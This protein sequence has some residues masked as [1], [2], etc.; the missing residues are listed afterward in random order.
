MKQTPL[1]AL[2]GLAAVPI[3]ASSSQAAKPL[4][5][6][7]VIGTWRNPKGSVYV[8]TELCGD[9][10]C[11]RIIC[12]DS[13][14]TAKAQS[15]GTRTLVGTS[16]FENYRQRDDGSWKGRVFI[17]DRRGWFNSTMTNAGPDALKI[18]GCT[19]LGLVCKEQIWRRV[20]ASS[21]PF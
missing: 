5:P 3:L 7:D 21:C 18:R 10:L 2:L 13:R 17:P 16:I 11:G 12:A 15:K 20:E 14:A 1:V 4:A 8:Q 6:S 9:R 19:F